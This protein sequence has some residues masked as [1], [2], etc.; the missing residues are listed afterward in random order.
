[1]E[2]WKR[3]TDGIGSATDHRNQ[4]WGVD[5]LTGARPGCLLR[6]SLERAGEMAKSDNY[7]HRQQ[8]SCLDGYPQP[9]VTLS[10]AMNL[11]DRR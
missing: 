4:H 11:S 2:P 6:T 10:G 5:A 3:P 7:E 8:A 9:L 1:M